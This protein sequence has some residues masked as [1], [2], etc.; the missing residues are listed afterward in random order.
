MDYLCF[1]YL[2]L[3]KKNYM[4]ATI[5]I[6]EDHDKV[7][8]A[9]R[10]LLEVK[11]SQYQVIEASSGEEVIALTLSEPPHLVIMDITLPGM[12]GIEA[13]RRIRT[14]YPSTQILMFTVHEDEI[15]REEAKA[16]GAC[17]Y[18]P[19]HALQSE[20]LPQLT[21]LLTG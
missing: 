17:A 12:S 16:A 18:V 4:P 15:Y 19:K 1:V 11:Y 8:S 3:G 21:S 7:R 13:T 5:L 2:M 6:V 14:T 9:L 20:L 10:N